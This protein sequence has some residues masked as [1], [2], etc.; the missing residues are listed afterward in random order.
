M[1]HLIS[2]VIGFVMDLLFGDPHGFPHI[3]VGMGKMITCFENNLRK[4]FP[5]T[6]KGELLGGIVLAMLVPALSAGAIWGVLYICKQIHPVLTLLIESLVVWQCLALRSLRD[7]SM[8]VHAGLKKKDWDAARAA[9]GRIVGRDTETLDNAGVTRAAVE[10]VAE[11]TSDGVIAP[12]L[13]LAIGGAPLGVFYK[14]VNTMDSMVGYKN[15]RYLYFGRT[16]ARLDDAL[17]FF[18]ARIAAILMVLAAFLSGE[19]GRN[20]WRI[21]RRDRCNHK[22]P[23]SAH[24]EAAC[25]GALHIRLGGDSY[26]FGELVHKPAIGDDDHPVKY[27]DIYR[28]TRL[29]YWTSSICFLLCAVT[30]GMIL[31]L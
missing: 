24:T 14:A 6:Q 22:S 13:F 11:N 12:L 4:V 26:Y 25:A 15:C 20:A 7:E 16:A 8:A 17:N 27:G 30:K 19:D 29:L 28:A 5:K 23:N 9:V 10:T 21:L 1:M 3:V 18:P 31:W 2:F